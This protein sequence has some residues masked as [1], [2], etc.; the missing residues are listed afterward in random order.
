MSQM[1]KYNADAWLYD[2]FYILTPPEKETTVDKI[3]EIA[4]EIKKSVG[5]DTLCID[6]FNELNHDYSN[7]A[8][9]EDKYLEHTLGKIRRFARQ[10]DV[11]IF[12]VAHPR[13]LKMEKGRYL[14][15]TAFEFSGGAAWYAKAETILCVYRPTLESNE[16]EIHIQKSKPKHT[17]RKGIVKLY[18]DWKKSRYYEK[19][20][21]GFEKY[22]EAKEITTA[23]LKT[24]PVQSNI[25]FQH[26]AELNEDSPF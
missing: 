14:P 5:L 18:W 10:H 20:I 21:S 9:R 11:H 6:P 25:N 12:V 16:V 3:L 7:H 17:G 24:P 26:E 8:G 15:P 22:S 13:T 1:E 19:T 23:G 4:L 2:Y